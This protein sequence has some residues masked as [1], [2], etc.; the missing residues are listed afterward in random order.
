MFGRHLAEADQT[1]DKNNISALNTP[2]PGNG[3]PKSVHQIDTNNRG[4][5]PTSILA[6]S[7]QLQRIDH[8]HQHTKGPASTYQIDINND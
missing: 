1:A 4:Q 3:R 2:T 6:K 8:Q 5:Q 7:G